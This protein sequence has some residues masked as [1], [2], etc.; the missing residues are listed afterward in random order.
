MHLTPAQQATF[1]AH[2]RANQN[3]TVVA[4]LAIRDDQTIADWYNGASAT[5]AWNEA[6]TRSDLFE[7]TPI[8]NFDGLT[9]GKRDAWKLLLEQASQ[10]PLDFGRVKLRAAVI[11]IWSSAQATAVLTACTRKATRGENVFGG[12]VETATIP[13]GNVVAT[14]LAL[15]SQFSGNEISVLLNL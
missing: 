14:D 6:M 12:V 13:G 11:D 10:A 4:A 5:D 7:A 2:I 15:E 9:A 8:T 3:A 1:A